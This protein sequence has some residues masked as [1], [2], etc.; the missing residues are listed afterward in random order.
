MLQGSQICPSISCCLLY[1]SNKILR[2]QI[3]FDRQG[4]RSDGLVA[5]SPNRVLRQVIVDLTKKDAFVGRFCIN[6]DQI[7]GRR[8]RISQLEA[9]L[10]NMRFINVLGNHKAIFENNKLMKRRNLYHKVNTRHGL[11]QRSNISGILCAMNFGSRF[12]A[13]NIIFQHR[14]TR[15]N[16]CSTMGMILHIR[17]LFVQTWLKHKIMNIHSAN[18]VILK[19]EVE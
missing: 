10:C 7:D 14:L 2:I 5:I 1:K 8:K 19:L 13:L 17:E 18:H 6:F 15:G 4:T 3:H 11:L 16:I 12:D 9:G